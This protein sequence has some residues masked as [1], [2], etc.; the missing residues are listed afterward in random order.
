M[1][2]SNNKQRSRLWYWLL[3]LPLFGLLFPGIYARST[4]ALFGFP[5]FYWY[6]FAW[7]L[8]TAAVTGLVYLLTEG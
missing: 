2:A 5:F 8:I 4:P 1:P 6:Q 7:V 3:L